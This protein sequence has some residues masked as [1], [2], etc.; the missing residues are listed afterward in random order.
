MESKRYRELIIIYLK[1]FAMGCADAIPGV[2]GGTIALIT[3]IY[4]RLIDSLTSPTKARLENIARSSLR[5]DFGEMRK[6]LRDM[7]L[8]FLMVLG[9]GVTTAIIFVLN[10]IH[11]LL[12]DFTV[13]TYGFFFGLIGAS[14]AVLYNQIDLSTTHRKIAALM[15]FS[16]AFIA[17]GYGATNLGNGLPVLFVAGG[18]AVSAMVLPG[19]SGSLLLIMLGQYEYISG[20]LSTFTGSALRAMK[21]GNLD[22]LISASPP[23]LFLLLVLSLAFFQ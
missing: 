5:L 3:G 21:T 16:I 2:S 18:I 23:I 11:L 13:A 15:G 1:G 22:S 17:S 19:I 6:I 12:S 4:E 8:P 10:I 9:M 14:A 20:A 7:D